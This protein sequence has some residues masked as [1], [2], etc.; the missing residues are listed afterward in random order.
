MRGVGE[1]TVIRPALPDPP[2]AWDAS[3]TEGSNAL[4]ET[5][6]R[7][8]LERPTNAWVAPWGHMRVS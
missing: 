5:H 2:Q 7:L 6:E 3:S 8:G 1:G 4:A